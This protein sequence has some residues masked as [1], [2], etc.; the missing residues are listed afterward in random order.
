MILGAATEMFTRS[1]Q[2]MSPD[3]NRRGTRMNGDF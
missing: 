3:T 1:A 2:A